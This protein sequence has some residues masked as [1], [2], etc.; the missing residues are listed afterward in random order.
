MQTVKNDTYF[1]RQALLQAKKAYTAG[2]VPV[3][4]VL[5]RQNQIIAR[6]YNK[7]ETN[8]CATAHAEL[9]CIQ[10]ACKK[11][12]N[13]RLSDCTL[14][15][16]LEPCP[17]CAG[18]IVNAHIPKI[19]YGAPDLQSGACG[20]FL[21]IPAMGLLNHTAE[22]VPNVLKEDCAALLKQFFQNVRSRGA[23]KKQEFFS[24]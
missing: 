8:R 2:E 15:V 24:K 17:M 18:A 10:K 9:L 20:S 16:T 11:L 4:A 7:R 13:W 14:Y 21:S 19:V 22:I 23:R 12:E 5:V 3:G 6:A 1:M